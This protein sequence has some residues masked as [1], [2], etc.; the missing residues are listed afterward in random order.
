MSWSA[1][2]PELQHEI[3]KQTLYYDIDQYLS[4]NQS[5]YFANYARMAKDLHRYTE[6]SKAFTKYCAL[7]VM[8]ILVDS[9]A[10][11]QSKIHKELR[12]CG[13]GFTL[14][15]FWSGDVIY[16]DLPAPHEANTRAQMVLDEKCVRVL[17]TLLHSI[18]FFRKL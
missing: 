15:P 11:M 1:L 7:P 2:P 3:I 17:N 5:P 12:K 8:R 9:V 6:I 14:F 16:W 10:T 13:Y 18:C 4:P